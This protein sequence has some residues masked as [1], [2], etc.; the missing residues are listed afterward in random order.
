[1]HVSSEALALLSRSI[2]VAG[3]DRDS[4][5]IRLRSSRSLGGTT[6]VQVEFVEQAGEEDVPIFEGD[7]RI[8]ADHRLLKSFPGG[9]VA[10]SSEHERVVVLPGPSA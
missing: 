7:I 4:V 10:V 1:M 2:E 3:L 5:G 9:T 6:D 8:Y